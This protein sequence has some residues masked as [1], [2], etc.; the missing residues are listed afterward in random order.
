M[1]ERERETHLAAACSWERE[2]EGVM[3]EVCQLQEQLNT[4]R[5]VADAEK[6]TA[7]EQSA[8]HAHTHTHTHTQ[9]NFLLPQMSFGLPT[10]S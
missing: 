2:K 10:A 1:L 7:L 8:T 9:L 4:H 5:A 6:K 3:E